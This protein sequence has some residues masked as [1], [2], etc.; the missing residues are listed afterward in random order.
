MDT[1]AATLVEDNVV[2]EEGYDEEAD[3]DFDE[4]AQDDD[5]SSSSSDDE[6]N[7]G[8]PDG[9]PKSKNKAPN[10]DVVTGELDSGDEATIKQ[11]QKTKK[12]P[13]NRD[14]EGSDEED[15]QWRAKTR[16]MR[17]HE[18][19]DRRQKKL[20]SL[21]SS[22]I[23]VNK[24][25]EEMNRP[26]PLPPVRMENEDAHRDFPPSPKTQ[27]ID[28]RNKENVPLM[29]SEE[30]ITIKRR[31]KFAGEI[32]EEEK[33]VPKSSAEA[34]LWLAQQESK[35]DH[36]PKEQ[37]LKQ[38]PLRKI[39]RFDPNYSNLDAFRNH[40]IRPGAAEGFKGP[41]LN[42]VEKSKMDWAVH[43]DA[44]GLKE[45]L[46]V[47]AK[48][49]DAYLNRMDFLGQVEQRREDEARQARLHG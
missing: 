42:V 8:E 43:V 48:A 1:M 4:Q 25:W 38:R 23:D 29:G 32:H 20:A 40:L 49:K 12:N 30:M 26:G 10:A 7:A 15:E 21:K 28:D 39:S 6:R 18:K 22:T 17:M 9:K 37:E 16:S 34:R 27:K 33:V 45:E 13:K 19:E 41:R 2:D 46:D 24:M 11:R 35:Q 14:E 47:H 36:S 5:I 31:F 44:E 3:S